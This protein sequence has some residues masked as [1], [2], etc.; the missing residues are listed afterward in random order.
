[1]VTNNELR[2]VNDFD[3]LMLIWVFSRPW[4]VSI[5][6]LFTFRQEALLYIRIGGSTLHD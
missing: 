3:D 1:M 2:V 5:D 6:T 4:L